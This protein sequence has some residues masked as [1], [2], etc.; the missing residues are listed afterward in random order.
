VLY[1]LEAGK[2]GMQKTSGMTV[3]GYLAQHPQE[4]AYVPHAPDGEL[5]LHPCPLCEEACVIPC[6][7]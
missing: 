1:C 2:T 7:S 3:F 5:L 6:V 4:A